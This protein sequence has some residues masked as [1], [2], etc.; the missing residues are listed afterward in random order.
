MPRY[1]ILVEGHFNLY[2]KTC[3][4]LLRYKQNEAVCCIDSKNEGKTTHS[5]LNI[6]GQTPIVKNV[7]NALQYN[8]DS[9]LIG[10][11]TQGGYLPDNMRKIVLSAIEKGLN[12]VSGLHEFLSNDVEM[13]N[14]ANKHGVSII[15]LRKPPR[16][17]PFTKGSWKNRKTPVLLTI[18]TDCDSGK[19]TAAWEIKNKLKERGIKAAFVGTGQTG[20]LL[21]ES[22]VAVD[23][24]ISDFVSGAIEAE[25]DK[26]EKGSDII[27]VEGQG[28]LLHTAYSG[29]TL[30]LLHGSMPD[31]LIMCHEPSRK[32]DTFD[33]PML[34]M[35]NNLQLNIDLM[36]PFK[37]VVCVGACLITLSENDRE[38]KKTIYNYNQEHSFPSDDIVRFGGSSIIDNIIDQMNQL[39]V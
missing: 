38:A 21:G 5:V 27:I 10:V 25:I 26:V 28:S 22:G 7:A 35:K 1:A 15:D 18:G 20:I 30:G 19:M 11:A 39:C 12:I 23:A 31:M 14:L 4:S 13:S 34:P 24:V 36:K 3:N 37:P 33:F 6:G 8:P 17:L 9:L 2:A 29:V 32:M 16:P